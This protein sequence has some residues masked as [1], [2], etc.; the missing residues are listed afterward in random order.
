[1]LLSL[2]FVCASAL[3]QAKPVVPPVDPARVKATVESVEHAFAKG[4]AEARCK[5]IQSASEVVDAAVIAAIARGF[6][7]KDQLTVRTASV[8]A[9]RKMQ[10][11]KAFDALYDLAKAAPTQKDEAFYPLVLRALAQHGDKRA[12]P[13]LR[14]GALGAAAFKIDQTRIIGLANIRHKDSVEALIEMMNT[15]GP[16][17]IGPFMDE[18]SLALFVL[19]GAEGQRLEDWQRWWNDNKKKLEIAPQMPELP[20]GK[21]MRWN[22]FWGIEKQG[23]HAQGKDEK[24]KEETPP[25]GGKKDAPMTPPG[26]KK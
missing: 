15:L 5:A 9:L 20:K 2:L 24:S 3:P 26:G 21:Q 14:D 13:L 16:Q 1:M 6:K 25:P 22:T 10:H 8:E 12:I 11:P 7:E 23:K 17:R 19:T 4:D 18:L